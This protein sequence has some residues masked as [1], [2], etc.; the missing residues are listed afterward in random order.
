MNR[1]VARAAAVAALL[2][3]GLTACELPE[4]LGESEDPPL[5]GERIS[6]LRLEQRLEPDPAIS[7]LAVRLPRPWRNTDWPQ[8]A[9][10]AAHAMYHLEAAE[11]LR[12]VWRIDAGEGSDSDMRLLAQPVVAGGRIYVLDAAATVRAFA[13]E[14]GRSLW[15]QALKPESEEDGALGGGLAFDGGLVFVTTGYG[16]IFALSPDSGEIVWRKQ[17]GAPVRGAPTAASGRVFAITYDNRMYALS[18]ADGRELW[19]HNGIPE[20]AGL[21]GSPSPAVDRGVVVAPYSSGEIFALRVENGRPLWSDQLT[22]STRSTPLSSLNE[23]RGSPVIDRGI[24]LAVSHS[25]RFAASDLQSGARV[26]DS[27][28]GGI[29]TP[30]VAGSFIFLITTQSELVCLETRSGRIRW[31]TQLQAY[32]DEEDRVDPIHWSG[33]L[34]VSDRLIAVSSHGFAAAISPYTGELLG[35]QELPAGVQIAP[36]VADGTIYIL[37]DS[38]TLVALR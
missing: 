29:E 37:T 17:L 21:V 28:I 26:W 13:A 12:V 31:V 15:R 11:A 36:I 14:S 24:V 9:G 27:D 19:Q 6:V 8:T 23:I 1:S 25:G 20:D 30:W 7:D 18:A 32:E 3:V 10:L 16:E 33:P 38:A 22:R 4:W 2:A 34:L 35:Q 5:P